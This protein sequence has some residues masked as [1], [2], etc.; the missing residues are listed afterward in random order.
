MNPIGGAMDNRSIWIGF[1]SREA[2]AFAVAKH[3]ARR[4]TNRAYP[5]RGLV[6][7][8]LRN[9]GLYRREVQKRPGP[10]GKPILWDPISD[11]PMSTE[12]AISRF[13]IPFLHNTGWALFMDCDVLIMAN[14]AQLFESLDPSKAM[15]CV[16]HKEMPDVSGVKMG[17]QGVQVPYRR[18]LWSSVMAW[19]LDH[20]ATKRLTL[21][22][23]NTRP[24]RDLH[25]LI[26][27]D[28]TEI[29]ALDPSWNH[30]VGMDP[31]PSTGIKLAHFTSGTPD[32]DGCDGCNFSDLWWEEL[33]MWATSC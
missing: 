20:P 22:M 19:N 7:D 31:I 25:S 5:I 13:F 1:D 23:V 14:L 3:S 12:F 18:K 27:L 2:A 32:M 30:L 33:A 10:A 9:H 24:G 29:G 6:L 4:R 21:E 8:Q 28:D 26:W 11:A 17:G 16:K 15:Y